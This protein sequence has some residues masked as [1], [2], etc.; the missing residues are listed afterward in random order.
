MDER[1]DKGSKAE[2]AFLFKD[3]FI[4][5][6]WDVYS[7]LLTEHQRDITNLYF[8]YDFSLTEIAEERNISRQSVSDCLKKCRKQLEFYE[9]KLGFLKIYDE[10]NGEISRLK[11]LNKD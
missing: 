7:P 11:N 6:L 2:G 5:R 1:G 10:L 9:E 4:L 8:N 3:E